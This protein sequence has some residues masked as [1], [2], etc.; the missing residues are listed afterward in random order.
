MQ[1]PKVSVIVPVHNAAATVEAC[2][3]S[4][5]EQ[6]APGL[7]CIL[8]E[9]HSEDDSLPVCRRLAASDARIRLAVCREAGVSAAR[10]LGLELATGDI[11]G[12]CDADD[13][14]EPGAVGTVV[15]LLR[16]HPEALG[17]I[18]AF[19]TGENTPE[20]IRK[21]YR[22]RKCRSLSAKKAIMLTVDSR[23]V[24]GSVWNKYYRAEAAKRFRFDPSL[25]YCEDTHY[26]VSLLSAFPGARLVYT[27]QPLYCYMLNSQSVTHQSDRLYD[28]NGEL[29]YIAALKKILQDCPLDAACRSVVRMKI[30][31]L[32]IDYLYAGEADGRRKAG[33]TAEWK[34][35]RR[36]LLKNAARFDVKDHAKQIVRGLL[37]RGRRRGV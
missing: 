1:Q 26:N 13:L 37:L 9:N 25:S 28:E 17:V 16:S 2:V 18:G 14:L 7:E 21:Q 23:T 27:G 5:L 29:R 6:E 30:A 3:R 36:Q 12:F 35:N 8:I 4:I 10:N 22:G 20:G 33:L 34:Q 32:A 11:I 15:S 24:M 31:S 19:Y